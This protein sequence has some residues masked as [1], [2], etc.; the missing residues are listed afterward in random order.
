MPFPVY[1]LPLSTVFEPE[2]QYENSQRFNAPRHT[3][4]Y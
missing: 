4:V 2:L 3:K 1:F